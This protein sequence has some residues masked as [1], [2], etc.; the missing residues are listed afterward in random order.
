MGDGPYVGEV[1]LMGG[2]DAPDG[3]APCDGQLL[4]PAQ[5]PQLFQ[6]IGTTYG[7]DGQATFALPDLRG[8]LPVHDGNGLTLGEERGTETHSLT[9]NEM[10]AHTHDHVAASGNA[11]AP[12]PTNSFLGSSANLY[13]PVSALTTIHPSSV[14]SVGSGQA[15]ENRQPY[16]VLNW[17]I[18][19]D[20][21]YPTSA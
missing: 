10:A 15:H 2:A 1:R 20:G 17:C 7:G 12:T 13:S 19:L 9:L 8:R 16:L 14:S 3:W 4:D 5:Y 18:A 21:I 6:L 11:N